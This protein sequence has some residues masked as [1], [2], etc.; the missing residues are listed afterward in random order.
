MLAEA[1]QKFADLI[2]PQT[3]KPEIGNRHDLVSSRQLF[4][5]PL[6]EEPGYPTVEL[7]SLAGFADFVSQNKSAGKFICCKA[8]SVEFL[9]DEVGENRKR[10]AIA[11]VT[12][13]VE[14]FHFGTYQDMENFRIQLMT[15][16]D[17]SEH[18]TALLKFISQLTSESAT[19]LADNG[20]TQTVTAKVGIATHDNLAV[21]SPLSL[22]P[23]R[24]FCEIAQPEGVFVLRL[25]K[26]AGGGVEAAL[27]EHFT[28]WQRTAAWNL[29]EYLNDT[30]KTELQDIG[31]F[32]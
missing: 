9:T 11:R 32:A 19:S 26:G 10:H 22:Q 12:C 4:N 27:F 23:V 16:F 15:R 30:H 13:K 8:Q 18:W 7:I 25:R 3:F 1:L 2:A 28:D 20:V 17:P 6:P 31:V 14:P 21:P 5:L 24:T 29:A